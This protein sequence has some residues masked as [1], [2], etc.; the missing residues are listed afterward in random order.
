MNDVE[1]GGE[2]QCGPFDYS[3]F[4]SLVTKWQLH[5]SMNN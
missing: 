1:Y 3:T 2:I 5:F 4:W